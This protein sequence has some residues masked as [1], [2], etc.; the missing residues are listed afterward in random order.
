MMIRVMLTG[1]KHLIGIAL[2][3]LKWFAELLIEMFSWL[4]RV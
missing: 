3:H 2:S 4:Y 1:G